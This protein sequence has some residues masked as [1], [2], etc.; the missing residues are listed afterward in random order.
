MPRRKKRKKERRLRLAWKE[1]AHDHNAHLQALSDCTKDM[2]IKYV[3]MH[4]P[5][6]CTQKQNSQMKKRGE[7]RYG[8]ERG[9]D[10]LH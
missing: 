10:D 9:C 6:F 4:A 7:G 5:F 8:V 2:Y 1:V 3:V